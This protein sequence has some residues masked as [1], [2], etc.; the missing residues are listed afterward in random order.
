MKSISAFIGVHSR[1]APFL[2]GL[3][4]AVPPSNI[5]MTYPGFDGFLGTRASFMLDFVFV[6][7]FAVIPIMGWSVYQ[8]KFNRRYTLHKWVQVTLGI[9]LAAAVTAFEIDIR[10]FGWEERA[11]GLPGGKPA[12]I[13]Y[14]V[15]WIHLC[16]AVSS[17]IL[18]VFVIVQALR[19]F[20]SPPR[21]CDY[22]RRHIFWGQLAAWDMFF[23]ALTGWAFYL[24]AFATPR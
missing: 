18:W 13:I 22:S 1:F 21:P 7:M 24:L 11:A 15:L 17:A 8:V 12:A 2:N 20:P 9:V 14:T 6:A 10:T 5:A 4:A 23:T 16:F 3:P 19:F